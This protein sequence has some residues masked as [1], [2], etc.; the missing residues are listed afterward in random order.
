MLDLDQGL[1]M[2]ALTEGG[3]RWRLR[4]RFWQCRHDSS[5]RGGQKG[6]REP[7]GRSWDPCS[8]G[9]LTER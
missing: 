1:F 4:L 8:V 9:F 3:G 5:R 6:D 2:A 7:R